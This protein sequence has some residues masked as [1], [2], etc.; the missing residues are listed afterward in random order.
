MSH[1]FDLGSVN[2][3]SDLIDFF[4]NVKGYLNKGG[5]GC[6]KI[7]GINVSFKV[8]GSGDE[9]QFAVDRGSMKEIDISGITDDRIN[10]RFPPGH[11]M[12]PAIKTL[13]AILNE[14]L[15]DIKGELKKLGMWDNSSLFLNTEYVGG[16]TNVVGYDENFLAIHGLNQFYERTA[17]SG[18]SKGN[19]RPGAARPEGVKAPSSEVPYNDATMNRLIDKLSSVAENYGFQVY[20]CVPTEKTGDIEFAETLAAPFA[21]QV[22]PDKEITQSLGEWLSN[23]QNPRYKPIKLKNGKVTHP[24]H[25]ELYKAVLSGAI[26]ISELVEE[27]SPGSVIDVINGALFM[28]ATR[29]LGNDV[30]GGLSSPMGPVINHEGVVLRDKLFGPNPVKITGE[31]IIGGMTSAFQSAEAGEPVKELPAA[32]TRR[33]AVLPG[34]FKPPHAGHL[35]MV[36]HYASLAELVLIL[37]SPLTRETD[38]ERIP[39]TRDDARRIWELYIEKA[40]LGDKVAI[41]GTPFESPVKTAYELPKGNVPDFIPQSGDLIIPAASDKPDPRSGLP[42]WH[43]FAKFQEM[44][45]VLPGVFLANAEEY[46]FPA[47]A[48]PMSATGL[49]AALETPGESAASWLPGELEKDDIARLITGMKEVENDEMT[50]PKEPITLENLFNMVE[51]VIDEE[52]NIEEISAMGGAPGAVGDGAIQGYSLP[53]GTKPRKSNKKKRRK[54]RRIYIPD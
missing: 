40:G 13:L 17:K 37:I 24:L 42:D 18:A 7:D 49:R 36:E 25:K 34:K 1:P 53:L 12:R 16:T 2:T 14:A 19:V 46:A 50:K 39:I 48:A 22:S 9:R 31:F 6:V 43:R 44:P 5:G 45:D 54:G 4:D 26:P 8:V 15:P 41:I 33:V 47:G 20:G 27:S 51:E 32:P 29:M 10:D 11:G 21:V 30:L 38:K 28:H 23:A 35:A 3:G 52:E